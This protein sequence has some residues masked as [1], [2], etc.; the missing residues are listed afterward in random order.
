MSPRACRSG[1]CGELENLLSVLRKKASFLGR[2]AHSL[3][4]YW[5]TPTPQVTAG[6]QDHHNILFRWCLLMGV[7]L[8]QGHKKG[9]LI[10]YCNRQKTHVCRHLNFSNKQK[11][12]RKLSNSV[13]TVMTCTHV[14][15]M[16]PYP[17]MG[18]I[19]AP[20][21][22]VTRIYINFWNVPRKERWNWIQIILYIHNS[23]FIKMIVIWSNDHFISMLW[24][25]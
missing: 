19:H 22:H 5:V 24:C 21:V 18:T 14:E 2:P 20:S 3:A 15:N 16:P 7:L 13:K 17:V 11:Q 10:L 9:K 25:L 12:C 1:R 23:V 8:L 4:L 6:A